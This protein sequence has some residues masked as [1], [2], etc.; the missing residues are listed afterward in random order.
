[1]VELLA[2]GTGETVGIV[3]LSA[4]VLGASLKLSGIAIQAMSKKTCGEGL[5]LAELPLC[6]KHTETLEEHGR[7]IAEMR[8]TLE[9][10]STVQEEMRQDLKEI[11]ARLPRRGP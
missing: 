11:L 7:K 6:V 10:Y 1:M 8:V 5:P 9:F 4:A 2:Q 3:A